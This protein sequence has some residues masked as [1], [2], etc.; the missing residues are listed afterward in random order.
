MKLK[1]AVSGG[2]PVEI[3]IGWWKR[4]KVDPKTPRTKVRSG[5]LQSS[6]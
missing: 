4:N 3:T 5:A 1:R 2:G 6:L